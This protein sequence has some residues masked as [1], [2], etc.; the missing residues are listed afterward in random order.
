[1]PVV[2]VSAGVLQHRPQRLHRGGELGE[3]IEM[4][5]GEPGQSLG[6]VGRER[7]PDDA[8]LI[9]VGGSLHEPR[10]LGSIDELNHAV[11]AQQQQVS[12]LADRRPF[13]AAVAADREH[14]L[15]L[16]RR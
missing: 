7:E 12:D 14:Q 6:A 8:M 3:L 16:C 4:L 11:M 13:R 2:L 9:T 5:N 15:V 10:C 1:M